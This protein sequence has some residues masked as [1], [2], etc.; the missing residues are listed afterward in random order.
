MEAL[1]PYSACPTRLFRVGS[2]TINRKSKYSIFL[3][4]MS[5]SS[6]LLNLGKVWEP[7]TWW[8][9]QTEIWGTPY[10]QL[11][12]EIRAALGAEP[13][14]LW[15]L[16]LT[17]GS[18]WVVAGHAV[19]ARAKVALEKAPHIWCQQEALTRLEKEGRSVWG[20]RPMLALR[21]QGRT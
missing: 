12:S 16:V 1:C 21:C 3:S 20:Q 14:N 4:S 17:S 9:R 13:L 8:P 2:C 6:K 18:V 15:S 7:L 5:F 19:G 11:V 10:L